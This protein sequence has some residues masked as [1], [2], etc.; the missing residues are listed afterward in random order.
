MKTRVVSNL[1]N[2]CFEVGHEKC[3]WHAGLS[4]LSNLFA[5]FKIGTGKEGGQVGW[6]AGIYY[7]VGL[8]FAY[9]LRKR[10]PRLDRLDKPR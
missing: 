2:L 10:A 7:F 9:N 4:N 5:L 3:L 8:V 1:S 6:A